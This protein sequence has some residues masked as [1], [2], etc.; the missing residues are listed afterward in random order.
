MISGVFNRSF[1]ET[2]GLVFRPSYAQNNAISQF[3]LQRCRISSSSEYGSFLADQKKNMRQ[4]DPEVPGSESISGAF[5]RAL[6]LDSE[7]GKTLPWIIPD[8]L[9]HQDEPIPEENEWLIRD[10]L[11]HRGDS[12]FDSTGRQ[13]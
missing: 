5:H 6:A 4:Q 2:V 12:I 1:R 3:F 7:T 10:R 13:N 9:A 11:P 8:R